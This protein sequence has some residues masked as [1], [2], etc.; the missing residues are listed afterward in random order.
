MPRPQPDQLHAELRPVVEHA[1]TSVG[2][3]LEDIDVR[4]AGRRTL[5]RVIVDS[6]TGVGLDDIASL[7]RSIAARL[8]EHDAMLGGSYTLEVTSPGVDRP[9]TAARHW[10]RAHL[11]LVEVRTRDA[12]SF[13]GRVGDAGEHAVRLL[14]DGYV[15]EIRY[16]QVERATVVVEF[17]QPPVADLRAL[18][19][20]GES[21]DAAEERT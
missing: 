13:T 9:L 16:T 5:V 10:R 15:R 8:D 11:R 19:G 3:D 4:P 2:F 7:S 14:V 17:R 18:A 20:G 12:E 6:D 21:G 1:V